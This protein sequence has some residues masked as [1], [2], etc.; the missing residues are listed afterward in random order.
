MASVAKTPLA[1]SFDDVSTS[2]GSQIADTSLFPGTFPSGDGVPEKPRGPSDTSSNVSAN[3][4]FSDAVTFWRNLKSL[5]RP[6]QEI[7]SVHSKR[8]T[9]PSPM[10]GDSFGTDIT[11]NTNSSVDTDDIFDAF[12][13]PEEPQELTCQPV[14]PVPITDENETN[15]G[16]EGRWGD[17]L[18]AALLDNIKNKVV[19]SAHTEKKKA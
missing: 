9:R 16:T 8:G 1:L 11:D 18:E 13:V 12:G 5:R 2:S 3:M 17:S 7:D 14:A 19:Q 10:R 15:E 6:L 4:S